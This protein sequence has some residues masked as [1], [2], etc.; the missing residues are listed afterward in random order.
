VPSGPT[1]LLFSDADRLSGALRDRSGVGWS[2]TP[3]APAL[4][5]LQ[6]ALDRNLWQIMV[7]MAGAQRTLPICIHR[8]KRPRVRCRRLRTSS[9]DP[10]RPLRDLRTANRQDSTDAAA[11][12]ASS[13]SRWVLCSVSNSA[14]Q[15]Q[16][17]LRARRRRQVDPRGFLSFHSIRSYAPPAHPVTTWIRA[18]RAA[19]APAKRRRRRAARRTRAPPTTTRRRPRRQ[20]R[21]RAQTALRERRR[22]PRGTPRPLPPK[23]LDTFILP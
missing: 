15:R 8:W 10:R 14:G 4:G 13:V 12:A 6:R 17:D 9:T 22:P 16:I 5:A 7:Q 3:H 1:Y 21:T 18:A 19:P 23:H 2:P 20:P 11:L